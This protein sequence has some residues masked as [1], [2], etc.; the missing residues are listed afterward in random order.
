MGGLDSLWWFIAHQIPNSFTSLGG[1]PP[2]LIM[3]RFVVYT[4]YYHE[5]LN[6]LGSVGILRII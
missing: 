1:L 3:L 2:E 5:Y 4:D 6:T